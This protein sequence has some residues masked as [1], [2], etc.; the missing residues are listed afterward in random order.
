MDWTNDWGKKY[1]V[2]IAYQ[3]VGDINDYAFKIGEMLNSLQEKYHYNQ[4]DSMLILKD[5]LYHE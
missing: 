2:L 5:I 4:L 3:K 1:P